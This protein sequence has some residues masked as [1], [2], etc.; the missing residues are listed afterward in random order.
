MTSFLEEFKRGNVAKVAIA[1]AIVGLLAVVGYLALDRYV[2]N[3]PRPPFAG[4]EIDPESLTAPLDE[5]PAA[6]IQIAPPPP[7]TNEPK[8]L[9]IHR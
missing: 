2:L 1:C 8:S 9:E 4:A 5:P 6:T 7:V 3:A